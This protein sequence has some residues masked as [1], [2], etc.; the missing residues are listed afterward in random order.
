MPGRSYVTPE[1][2]VVELRTDTPLLQESQLEDYD[3]NVII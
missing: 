3:E 2:V 1:I